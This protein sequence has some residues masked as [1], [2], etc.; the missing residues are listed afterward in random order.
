MRSSVCPTY[1]LIFR[2]TGGTFLTLK[3][4]SIGLGVHIIVRQKPLFVILLHLGQLIEYQFVLE[5]ETTPA[6]LSKHFAKNEIALLI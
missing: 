5:S 6:K 4:T 2:I 1:D 3:P